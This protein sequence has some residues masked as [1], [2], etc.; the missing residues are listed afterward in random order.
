M[1]IRVD[2]C[3]S[4]SYDVMTQYVKHQKSLESKRRAKKAKK[5]SGHDDAMLSV[6]TGAAGS[7]P[8][9]DF[10][11]EGSVSSVSSVGANSQNLESYARVL[12]RK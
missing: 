4:W 2:V 12:C 5:E 9:E 1:A 8:P 7:Q 3:K 10:M 6:C 11:E